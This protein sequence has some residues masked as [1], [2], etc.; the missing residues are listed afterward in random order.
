MILLFF[1]AIKNRLFN[2]GEIEDLP[3]QYGEYNHKVALLLA[4]FSRLAY[5]GACCTNQDYISRESFEA[6]VVDKKEK[7]AAWGFKHFDYIYSEDTKILVLLARKGADVVLSFR[8]TILNSPLNVRL[9]L[10]ARLLEVPYYGSVH[11]GF[12][13]ALESVWEEIVNHPFLGNRKRRLWLTGHSLGGAMAILAGIRFS[14]FLETRIKEPVWGIYTFA[15]PRVGDLEFESVFMKSYLAERTFSFVHY[16]DVVTVVPPFVKLIAEYTEVGTIVY[17]DKQGNMEFRKEVV[18]FDTLR[19]FLAGY[20]QHQLLGK[21][22]WETIIE[23]WKTFKKFMKKLFSEIKLSRDADKEEKKNWDRLK[24]SFAELAANGDN[25]ALAENAIE[26]REQPKIMKII[27]DLFL[28][29]FLRF[30]PYV[31]SSHSI[32]TYINCIEANMDGLPLSPPAKE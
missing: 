19:N 16:N 7:V 1:R 10:Q 12:Y 21:L 26:L 24:K 20:F 18:G 14:A 31:V 2:P 23:D 29:L 5:P 25:S 6:D 13:D 8:G 15:A 17:L 30:H 3:E 11:Q 22:D 4:K 27:L 32:E 28:D 9:D